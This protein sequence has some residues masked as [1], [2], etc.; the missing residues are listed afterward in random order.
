MPQKQPPAMTAV[1]SALAVASVA[2]TVGLGMVAPG[3]SPALLATTPARITI[4]SPADTREGKLKMV[5]SFDRLGSRHRA[6]LNRVAAGRKVTDL[7]CGAP[8]V[9]ARPGQV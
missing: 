5:N 2:S 7:D 3:R 9:L 6:L 1:C 8:G 4:K